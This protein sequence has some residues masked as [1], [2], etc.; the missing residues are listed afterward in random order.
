MP[1]SNTILNEPST[2][3]IVEAREHENDWLEH[4]ENVARDGY[5][6]ENVS[7]AA[8]HADRLKNVKVVKGM[9]GLLPLFEESAES[10]AMICHAMNLCLAA[11]QHL[12]PGQTPVLTG[13]QPLYAMAKKCQWVF[14]SLFGEDKLVIMFGG[15]HVEMTLFKCIG[16]FLR[17][18]GWTDILIDARIATSGTAESFLS[19]SDVVKTR[20]AHQ[21]SAAVLQIL[22]KQAFK[23]YLS[24]GRKEIKDKFEVWVQKKSEENVNFKYWNDVLEFEKGCTSLKNSI[25]YKYYKNI[26]YRYIAV[27]KI[28]PRKELLLVC[29]IT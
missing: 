20:H 19:C 28:N 27:R 8:F 1:H 17:G 4:V 16:N 21:V 24:D 5:N 7:W 26:F 3:A 29:R 6:K 12:N 13:D 25:H 10:S 2:K 23:N 22:Q 18:S 14:P 9:S 11:T 15:L